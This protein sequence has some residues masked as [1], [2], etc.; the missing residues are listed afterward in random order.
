LTLE[1]AGRRFGGVK[2]IAFA[3][4]L[5]L[6]AAAVRADDLESVRRLDKEISVATWTAD[7]V[8]FQENL[9]ED[10]VLISPAGAMK[11]KREVIRELAIPGMKMEP[12][13]PLDVQVRMYSDTAVVTGRMQ[14]RFTL[15]GIRYANDLRY[16][17]VWVKRK[18]RW[19]LASAHISSIAVKR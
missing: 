1:A 15:G 8:W 9:A 3:A 10:Y 7:P 6:L 19:Q 18:G 14:Q 2:S 16:T 17:D 5:C 4:V 12:Y 11:S 13:E